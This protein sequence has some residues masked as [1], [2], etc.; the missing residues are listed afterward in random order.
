MAPQVGNITTESQY[1]G[2]PESFTSARPSYY[3]P[4]SWPAADLAASMAAAFAASALALKDADLAYANSLMQYAKDLYTAAQ[5]YPGRCGSLSVV[6]S[7]LRCKA[8]RDPTISW[9]V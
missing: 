4:T 9:P 2:Y 7:H 6:V 5:E 3:V 1:W 8:K